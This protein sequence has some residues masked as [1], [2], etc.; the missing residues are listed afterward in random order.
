VKTTIALI[1]IVLIWG[2]LS[3]FLAREEVNTTHRIDIHRD[4]EVL[5]TFM[6]SDGRRFYCAPW[7]EEPAP[8]T[9][10]NDDQETSA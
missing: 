3:I 7:V 5:N 8:P 9:P 2:G 1:V 10:R 4:C 6:T